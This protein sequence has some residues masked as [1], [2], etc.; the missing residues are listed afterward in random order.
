MLDL[1]NSTDL[2]K[3]KRG[4]RLSIDYS[5]CH[6]LNT[7]GRSRLFFLLTHVVFRTSILGWRYRHYFTK[8][9]ILFHLTDTNEVGSKLNN[10]KMLWATIM[11]YKTNKAVALGKK[12]RAGNIANESTYPH[13]HHSIVQVVIRLLPIDSICTVSM[14]LKNTKKNMA[15]HKIYLTFPNSLSQSDDIR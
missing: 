4:E 8:F 5:A 12:I 13:L 10:D 9:T 6:P 2:I 1:L 7:N 15:K 14:T 11:Y 3:M